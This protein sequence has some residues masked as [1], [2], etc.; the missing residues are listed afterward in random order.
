M[1]RGVKSTQNFY[2]SEGKDTQWKFDSIKSTSIWPKT[3][4]SK[5]KKKLNFNLYSSIKNVDAL[6]FLT[7]IQ[8]WLKEENEKQ[9][10][11]AQ[12]KHVLSYI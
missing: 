3:Y 2:S 5:S 12:V 4:L 1:S 8:V 6:F 11:M 10:A 7:D 9:N